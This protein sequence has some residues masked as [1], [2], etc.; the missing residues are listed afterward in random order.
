M[1]FN[2]CLVTNTGSGP[3]VKTGELTQTTASVSNASSSIVAADAS[4]K[5]LFI[6]NTG[7]STVYLSLDGATATVARGIALLPGAWVEPRAN[8]QG[9]IT[10]IRSTA[11]EDVVVITA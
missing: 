6:Q 1:S 9:A 3:L 4:R 11:T 2:R 5:Y 8:I 7:A 10:G